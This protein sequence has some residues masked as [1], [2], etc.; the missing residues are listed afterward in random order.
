M[1][2]P[3]APMM[4][5]PPGGGMGGGAMGGAGGGMPGSTAP[6]MMKPPGGKPGK[7]LNGRTVAGL[8]LQLLSVAL[9]QLGPQSEEGIAVAKAI[10]TLGAKFAKP[11]ADL[12]Q[13][14]MKFMQ[15]QLSPAPRPSAM[16]SGPGIRQSL[17]SMGA[18]AAPTP[19]AGMPPT[20]AP[21]TPGG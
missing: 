5:M 11:A 12:G 2:M 9:P 21:L 18:G 17:M 16:D 1:P 15:S 14:E 19:P 3:G 10:A 8:A 13:A 20:P 6:A 4:P 7:E